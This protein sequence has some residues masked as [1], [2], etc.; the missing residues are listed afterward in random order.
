M[1]HGRDSRYW[2]K[3][4]RRRDEDYNE[5]VVE[6]SGKAATDEATVKE[7]VPVKVKNVE[8]SALDGSSVKGSDRRGVGLYNEAGRNELKMYEAEYEASL[9]NSGTSFA[10]GVHHQQQFDEDLEKQNEA[11]DGIDEYDDGID[12]H[13]AHVDD[14][15]E[16]R[17]AE[18]G[19]SDEGESDHKD[20][21]QSLGLLDAESN[22]RN[23]AEKVE[24]VSYK[25]TEKNSRS[26]DEVGTDTA[27][28]SVTDGHSA[29]K[30]KS[31]SKRKG[32]RHKFSGNVLFLEYKQVSVP[33]CCCVG[34]RVELVS[35]LFHTISLF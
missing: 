21:R 23:S 33:L 2:D 22:Y 11:V 19:H 8:K 10:E 18:G 31:D 13:D 14:Y 3:D 27:N 15:G 25:S 5:D 12:Y 28:V 9:K 35:F 30:S 7:H 32:K 4:D 24:E 16:A 1:V 17:H 20:G 34:K 26:L 29:R 6:H